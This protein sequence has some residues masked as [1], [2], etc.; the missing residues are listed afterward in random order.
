MNELDNFAPATESAIQVIGD[1]LPDVEIDRQQRLNTAS[2]SIPHQETVARADDRYS[3]S[4]PFLAASEPNLGVNRPKPKSWVRWGIG[5]ILLGLGLFGVRQF[6]VS[7]GDEL[8]PA[9]IAKN[10]EIVKQ[11]EFA[12]SDRGKLLKEKR[13]TSCNLNYQNF[14]KA[15]LSGA[16][17]PQSSLI[18]AN[19]ANAN[20]TL[21]I[22]QDADLSGANLSK[23]NLQQAAFYG[24]QLTGANLAGANLTKAK[25][26]Y[27][28]LKGSWL[29]DA[30]LS[31]A[32]L[33]FA[34]FQQ[35][36]LTNANLSGADLSNADL[37]Y[38]NLRHAKLTGAKLTATNLTG[39]TMPDGSIHP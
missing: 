4:D 34:E 31:S 30:N 33:K 23:A 35:V 22:F 28:K 6:L 24:A 29:R 39:T 27:A 25:L 17:V 18:G 1:Q 9:Q 10:Q 32:D 21:A 12:A 14:A 26:V 15:E 3:S 2:I 38:A 11:A 20:L 19:F 36:D 37:S 7:D 8:S 13:C 5:G 16:I